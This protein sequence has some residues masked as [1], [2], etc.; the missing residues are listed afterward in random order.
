MAFWLRVK[1]EIHPGLRHVNLIRS[2]KLAQILPRASVRSIPRQTTPT[3]T[4]TSRASIASTRQFGTTLRSSG[5]CF[6]R[7]SPVGFLSGS[8]IGAAGILSSHAILSSSTRRFASTDSTDSASA[9]ASTPSSEFSSDFSSWTD[10]DSSSLLD[11]T[12]K[13]GF[14]S[15]LGLDYGIGPT[16]VLKYVLEH[17]HFTAGL[18]WWASVIG[19]AAVVRVALFYPTLRGQQVSARSQ[20]MRKDPVYVQTQQQLM[21]LVLGGNAKPEQIMELRMQQKLLQ[22]RA[23]VTN[24][25][26]FLPMALQFPIIIGAIRLTRSMAALP[27]PGLESAGTLWFTDLTMPDPLYVLPLVS[28]VLMY[29]TF[30]VSYSPRL[31]PIDTARHLFSSYI[32]TLC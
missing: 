14:L 15:N 10:L 12:E 4:S 30:Q 11:L 1:Y 22:E 23:G 21:A 19:L 16:S 17:L 28:M 20:E 25:Q 29:F 13:V 6:A 7:G 18:P 2:D 3:F 31:R 32:G 24:W 5:R 9:E 26:M 8:R 27:V